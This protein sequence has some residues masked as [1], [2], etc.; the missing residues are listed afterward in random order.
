MNTI[1]RT[2]FCVVS[3]RLLPALVI[4]I[5]GILSQGRAFYCWAEG[6]PSSVSVLVS[7]QIKPYAEALD[8]LVTGMEGKAKL[9]VVFMNKLGPQEKESLFK[10]IQASGN[11]TIAIGTEAARDS[12]IRLS[13]SNVR[14]LYLMALNPGEFMDENLRSCGISLNIPE[15]K[16]VKLIFGAMP[17]LQRLGLIFDPEIND[18]FFK[19]ASAAAIK[20]GRLIVPVSIEA[21]SDIPKAL[22]GVWNDVDGIWLIPDRT[23]ISERI[24]EFIVKESALRGKPVIGYNRFFYDSGSAAAFV[25]DY[26]RLGGQMADFASEVLGG[27]NC[28]STEPVFQFVLNR[29][30]LN[31]LGI[32]HLAPAGTVVEV[33]D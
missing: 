32:K 25:F 18:R 33:G 6:H 24:V 13:A 16:Q 5:A 8:G 29:K 20:E 3:F 1:F 10:K 11:I 23:V 14:V 27:K 22:A 21:R 19:T 7:A 30:V 28:T 2:V 4:L 9:D 15:N 31:K 12:V 26:R 17:S